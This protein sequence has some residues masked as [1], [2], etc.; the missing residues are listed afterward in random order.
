M[1]AELRT[2]SGRKPEL[3]SPATDRFGWVVV[4]VL[5]PVYAAVFAV[6]IE[7]AKSAIG[8]PVFCPALGAAVGIAYLALRHTPAV[9]VGLFIA[10]LGGENIA[11]LVD[12]LPWQ[13]R[14]AMSVIHGL[15]V[16]VSAVVAISWRA[17]HHVVGPQLRAV[18][19][20]LV[21]AVSGP[22]LGALLAG[23]FASPAGYEGSAI[24]LAVT[25]WLADV[26]G[27]LVVMPFITSLSRAAMDAWRP[28]DILFPG[29]AVLASV[30]MLAATALLGTGARS[31]YTFPGIFV[32]VWIA[33]RLGVGATSAAV[34]LFA[35]A[36]SLATGWQEGPF[37]GEFAAA[38]ARAFIACYVVVL[39]V[40]SVI[41]R[42]RRRALD[43]AMQMQVSLAK[44]THTDELTS[45][46]TRRVLEQVVNEML[47]GTEP[48]DDHSSALLLALDFDDFAA[49]NTLHGRACADDA[50]R[51]LAR[52]LRAHLPQAL[53]A[54]RIGGDEFAVL[55]RGNYSEGA[56]R[57]AADQLRHLMA[58]PV[59]CGDIPISVTASV[60]AALAHGGNAELLLRDV[61]AAVHDAKAAGRN[62]V[63][64]RTPAEREQADRD[65]ELINRLPAALAGREFVCVYQPV[66]PLPGKAGERGVE[67]LTRWRH[68]VRGELVPAQFLGPLQRAG[69]MPRLGEYLLDEALHNAAMWRT[70]VSPSSPRWVAINMSP[71][72]LMSVD[73]ARRVHTSLAAC[74]LP[75]HWLTIEI[76][77]EAMVAMSGAVRGVLSDIRA[78]GV[79]VAVDDFGTGFSGLSYLTQLPID[80]V[81]LDRQFLLASEEVRAKQL[82]K[83][84]CTLARDLGLRTVVEGVETS[85]QYER[86]R[87]AGADA[88]QG[89]FVGRP[90]LAR[91]F[92]SVAAAGAR[93]GV[94]ADEPIDVTRETRSAGP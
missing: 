2:T 25:W 68:P 15:E 82:L 90:A 56:A 83:S 4:G 24:D 39:L 41:A 47:M 16:V 20:I 78:L 34:L 81:K 84:V 11:W 55:L 29:E 76:T 64:V 36:L 30:T 23:V 52:R 42:E 60:G 13:Q 85:E 32:T 58:V 27:V 75:P 28:S 86:A 89:W 63:V 45:L 92:M 3:V 73:L 88:V 54:A 31:A 9:W 19:V 61:E 80:I 91:E 46:A 6:S 44:A 40:V 69:L 71:S 65:Q 72:E 49:V 51:E 7:V 87:E 38:W 62:R 57:D 12:G 1:R 37:V 10:V 53:C 59:F 8:I 74:G 94:G 33:I 79:R 70:T 93:D 5:L 50:L 14:L 77:E 43:E 18:T 48:L 21:A 67:M 17:R 22:T 66:V 26:L 35:S